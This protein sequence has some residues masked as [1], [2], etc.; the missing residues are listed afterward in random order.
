MIPTSLVRT[1][2]VVRGFK[3]EECMA[4][5]C[6]TIKWSWEDDMGEQHTFLI[7]NS[8]FVPQAISRLLCP[9]LCTKGY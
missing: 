8:Y 6:G 1:C 3:G 2:K 9:Q 5:C 7:P 4:T